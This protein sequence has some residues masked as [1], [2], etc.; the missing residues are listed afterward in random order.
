MNCQTSPIAASVE[1]CQPYGSSGLIDQDVRYRQYTL[2]VVSLAEPQVP[3]SS[4]PGVTKLRL[5]KG[6]ERSLG[7]ERNSIFMSRFR[8]KG[9]RKTH[10]KIRHLLS[11]RGAKIKLINHFTPRQIKKYFGNSPPPTG[12]PEIKADDKNSV[13]AGA[14]N[15][16]IVK[17]AIKKNSC[18]D[19]LVA[20]K[21]IYTPAWPCIN[22]IASYRRRS[23]SEICLQRRARFC[24]P[25]VY[26]IAERV[27]WKKRCHKIYL[28]M[29]LIKAP[30]LENIYDSLTRQEKFTVAR[31]LTRKLDS[32]HRRHI[33]A[34]DFK[35][36]NV[37][38]DPEN[39]QIT[40]IDFGCSHDLR[41]AIKLSFEHTSISHYHAPEIY[42]AS[43]YYCAKAGCPGLLPPAPYPCVQKNQ[44]LLPQKADIYSL[45]VILAKMF[46]QL[47]SGKWCL[48]YIDRHLT[49][50]DRFDQLTCI[51]MTAE[52]LDHDLRPLITKMLR[53]DPAL[54]PDLKAVDQTLKALAAPLPPRRF[55]P[56]SG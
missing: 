21:K 49:T 55:I 41:E 23:M 13:V 17:M 44:L 46:S 14:G 15:N 53:A 39:L 31:S 20:V 24:A 33:Y 3:A 11:E 35:D 37:L 10:S 4:R 8:K 50:T 45:G 19:E 38:I 9:Q 30:K 34:G 2:N 40:I 51:K 16:T 18:S 36:S 28:A 54:R 56:A 42:R 1:G 5:K 6:H 7:E 29:E 25:A 52:Q 32:L 22:V 27:D 12:W 26:G 48:N 43:R 47:P